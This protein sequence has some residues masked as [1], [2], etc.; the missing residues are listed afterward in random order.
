MMRMGRRV[1]ADFV[2]GRDLLVRR[3]RPR[4]RLACGLAERWYTVRFTDLRQERVLLH[5]GENDLSVD[6][7]GAIGSIV[8]LRRGQ[9]LRTGRI[10]VVRRRGRHTRIEA[11]GV[12]LL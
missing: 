9:N 12:L 2:V 1:E 4:V 10:R 8:R 7:I 11:R 5:V 6:E 3:H